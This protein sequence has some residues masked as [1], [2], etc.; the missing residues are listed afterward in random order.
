MFV[1]GL[2]VALVVAILFIPV[3]LDLALAVDPEFDDTKAP[4]PSSNRARLTWAWGAVAIDL[5]DGRRAGRS[6]PQPRRPLRLPPWSRL[7]ALV[8]PA[9]LLVRR[10]ARGLKTRNLEIHGEVDLDDPAET[11]ALWVMLGPLA[12]WLATQLDAI[13]EIVPRFDGGRSWVRASG[14][15]RLVPVR[16]LGPLLAFA[17]TPAL[18]RAARAR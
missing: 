9:W 6:K 10:V 15:F 8:Q 5:T 7:G 13:V 17:S 12:D 1:L 4:R 18:W 2:G 16:I 11:G 14:Q 3:E